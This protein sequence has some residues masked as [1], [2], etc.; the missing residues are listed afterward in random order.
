M[1]QTSSS[2]LSTATDS[3]HFKAKPGWKQCLVDS[4]AKRDDVQTLAEWSTSQARRQLQVLSV[5]SFIFY[6]MLNVKVSFFKMASWQQNQSSEHLLCTWR[7][8]EGKQTNEMSVCFMSSIL[9]SCMKFLSSCST[10][11]LFPATYT[12]E[13]TMPRVL[14]WTLL[15]VAKQALSWRQVCYTCWNKLACQYICFCDVLERFPS[16]PGCFLYGLQWD[17][18]K[19]GT[20]DL[21]HGGGHLGLLPNKETI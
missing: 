1:S 10:S 4:K 14:H 11:P 3:W 17:A 19:K 8:D 2:G 5:H 18:M 16:I 13:P 12:Q 21:V 20:G 7:K 9:D 15:E 6:E